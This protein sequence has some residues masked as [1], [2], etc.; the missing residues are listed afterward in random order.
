M[1]QMSDWMKGPLRP[2]T[3]TPGRPWSVSAPASTLRQ[4]SRS[5]FARHSGQRIGRPVRA[6]SAA[7][8]FRRHSAWKVCPHPSCTHGPSKSQSTQ[9]AH[10]SSG[11]GS[12]GTGP[13]AARWIHCRTPCTERTSVVV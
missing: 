3:T 9:M 13:A 4:S 11:S 12:V 10:P 5:M 2:M 1:C 7:C 8:P 6:A